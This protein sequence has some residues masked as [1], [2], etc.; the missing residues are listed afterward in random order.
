MGI[1][2]AL[3]GIL[4]VVA[5]CSVLALEDPITIDFSKF[6]WDRITNIPDV[7]NWSNKNL[8][9]YQI[10]AASGIFDNITYNNINITNSDNGYFDNLFVENI[11]ALNQEIFIRSPTRYYNATS[12]EESVRI[13]TPNNYF[14]HSTYDLGFGL[15]ASNNIVS[16]A[17]YTIFGL[18]EEGVSSGTI[19]FTGGNTSKT[20]FAPLTMWYGWNRSGIINGG[21]Y[22]SMYMFVEK[23]FSITP[24]LVFDMQGGL[25]TL[26]WQSSG[27]YEIRVNDSGDYFLVHSQDGSS[28]Y[29]RPMVG[30][31]E[32]DAGGDLDIT[33]TQ[34]IT[35]RTTNYPYGTVT[36]DFFDTPVITATSSYS[37]SN[38]TIRPNDL[39][40]IDGNLTVT[41]NTLLEGN[42]NATNIFVNGN[43]TLVNTVW[44]DER[45]PVTATQAGGSKDPHFIKAWDNGAGSQGVFTYAFDP[46]QEEE[47]YF[48]LQLPHSYKAGTNLK[49]HVHF[50]NKNNNAGNIVWGLEYNCIA[51]NSTF[52]GTTTLSTVTIANGGTDKHS[53][54]EIPEI[55]GTNFGAS[56]MCV[57]RV[58]R[59]ATNGADTY[60]SDSYLMEIDFHFQKDKIGT[61]TEYV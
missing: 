16:K 34:N 35:L 11:S 38:L 30:K 50:F 32:L 26:V 31:V 4:V 41:K 22:L 28:F 25:E 53:Y 37:P 43:L 46:S 24:R 7:I 58:Y 33:S 48:N 49:P 6:A 44:D 61:D 18:G 13:G 45:I 29:I 54:A 57:C 51:V 39:L 40:I 52:S 9:V 60:G 59:D 55:T 17:N 47:L 12:V 27:D 19:I 23:F 20:T 10:I 42:L 1:N 2:K 15:G 14:E 56:T 21:K 36:F 3:I 5:S 8:S